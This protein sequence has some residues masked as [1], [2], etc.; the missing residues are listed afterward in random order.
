[1]RDRTEAEPE[2]RGED[3]TSLRQLMGGL[4]KEMESEDASAEDDFLAQ[5]P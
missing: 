5:G 4:D 1:M 3:E 2:R